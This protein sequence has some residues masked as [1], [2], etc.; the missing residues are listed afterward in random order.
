MGRGATFPEVKRSGREADHAPQSSAGVNNAWSYTS[1]PQYSFM[2]WCS[3]KQEKLLHSVVLNYT[4]RQI[5]IYFTFT[6]FLYFA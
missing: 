6:E 4:Q 1:I 3:V 5:Y 2:V